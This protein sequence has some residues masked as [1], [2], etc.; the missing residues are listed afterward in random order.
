MNVIA[1]FSTIFIFTLTIGLSIFFYY[2]NTK[3]HFVFKPLPIA[4]MIIY[5]TIFN[6]SHLSE[7]FGWM[8]I[9]ALVFCIFGDL[10]IVYDKYFFYG[11]L[12]FL[13]T[14]IIYCSYF[15]LN[16]VTIYPWIICVLLL[17]GILAFV[18]LLPKHNDDFKGRIIPACLVYTLALSTMV[19]LAV[20]H[21]ISHIGHIGLMGVGAILFIVSDGILSLF[22]FKTKAKWMYFF[23]LLTYYLSQL[24]MPIAVILQ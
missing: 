18:S 19:G 20:C 5:Y 16:N 23:I 7:H 10:F 12:S 17:C 9:I 13:C 14:Q 1:V 21:D 11:I 22:Q 4:A 6:F 8:I 15:L 24:L 3:L 2:K